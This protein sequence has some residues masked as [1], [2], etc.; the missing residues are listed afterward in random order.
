MSIFRS[1]LASF[2]LVF[3]IF[4]SY[5]IVNR[6][7]YVKQWLILKPIH[8]N[9]A[10][11]FCNNFINCTDVCLL[12]ANGEDR[13]FS[14][15]MGIEGPYIYYKAFSS[16]EGKRKP[17]YV[18]SHWD[19]VL[20]PNADVIYV[21]VDGEPDGLEYFED[22]YPK[23]LYIGHKKSVAKGIHNLLLFC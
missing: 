19:H 22:F 11:F 2:L 9:A 20:D 5:F 7:Y 13:V 3:I 1:P 18:V 6:N 10:R 21:F 14:T 12:F 15:K 17:V 16:T 4:L 8:D 23:M